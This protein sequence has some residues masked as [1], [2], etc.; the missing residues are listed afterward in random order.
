VNWCSRYPA[1]IKQL[2]KDGKEISYLDESWVNNAMF[3]KYWQKSDN[4]RGIVAWRNA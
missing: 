2:R 4:V 3:Q 1:K